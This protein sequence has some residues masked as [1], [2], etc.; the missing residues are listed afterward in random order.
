[1][2][3]VDSAFPGGNIIVDEIINDR[4]FVRQDLR[5]TGGDWFYWYFRVRGA[6][7]RIITVT[8][9][10]SNVI[11][12][13]GPAVSID[14]AQSW[15]WLGAQAVDDQSFTYTVP[16]S[17]EEVRFCFAMPYMQSNLD[18]FLA[19]HADNPNL[20]Q[21]ELCVTRAGRSNELLYLG[22]LDGQCDHRVLLTCRHHCC[23]MMASYALEGIM[24]TVLSDDSLGAWFREHV[25]LAVVPFT[26]KD[27]V[28]NG[29]Q[30]KNRRPHDHNR[31]YNEESLY[32]SVRAIRSLVSTWSGGRLR[33]A[34]DMHCP[35][36]RGAHNQSIYFPGSADQDNWRR[37]CRFSEILQQ[38]QS[39]PLV[40]DSRNNLPFGQAWNTA[41]NYRSGKSFGRW[42]SEIPGISFGGG[43]EIPYADVD[44]EAVTAHSARALGRDLARALRRYLEELDTGRL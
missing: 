22:R 8:F 12:V 41:A 23:E 25:E 24:D 31:D 32:P 18:A 33:V 36:I 39:G 29:D 44:G 9:T 5:D 43:I 1:M 34:L 42:A 11:G 16:E 27:G 3:E 6:A 19:R 35:H 38:D 10:G 30:G 37:V 28:E 7:S 17:T 40:F 21:E 13:R 15:Q 2:I 4:I 14:G 26:D 20:Q